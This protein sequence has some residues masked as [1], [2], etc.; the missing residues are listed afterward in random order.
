MVRRDAAQAS[1]RLLDEAE[2]P[3]LTIHLPDGDA[4]ATSAPHDVISRGRTYRCGISIKQPKDDGKP[5]EV[6][7]ELPHR[8]HRLANLVE[9]TLD[10]VPLTLETVTDAD[11]DRV[12]ETH[13][14]LLLRRAEIGFGVGSF[15][16][17]Q[18]IPVDEPVSGLRATA[19]RFPGVEYDF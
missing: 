13:H 1:Q 7:V 19:Q 16:L 12:L 17:I 8:G 14:G 2:F 3:L 9:T 6:S 11:P 5:A 15:S 10:S 4:Y 18:D